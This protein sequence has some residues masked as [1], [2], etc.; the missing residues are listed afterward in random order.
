MEDY[1]SEYIQEEFFGQETYWLE[2]LNSVTAE[3][4]TSCSPSSSLI[5]PSQHSDSISSKLGLNN[6]IE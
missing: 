6:R 2:G 1:L 4:E 5:V 3:R